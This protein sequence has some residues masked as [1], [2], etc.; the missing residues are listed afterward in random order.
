MHFGMIKGKAGLSGMYSNWT[1]TG[2]NLEADK[3][4]PCVFSVDCTAKY[5]SVRLY[6]LKVS[7]SQKI[8]AWSTLHLYNKEHLK[9]NFFYFFIFRIQLRHSGT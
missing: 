2:Q 6:H 7:I 5:Y 4:S 9:H 8:T 3:L 1:R